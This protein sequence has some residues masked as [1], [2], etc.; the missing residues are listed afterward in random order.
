MPEADTSHGEYIQTVMDRL[1][2][3]DLQ[4]RYSMAIDAGCYDDLDDLFLPDVVADYGAL[5]ELRGVEAVK[6]ACRDALEPLTVAQHVNANH[7]ADLDGDTARAGCY[8]R[9]HQHREGTP[10]GEHFAMGGRYD[11]DVVR[12]PDG[13]RIARRTLRVL[14]AEGNPEVRWGGR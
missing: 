8:F 9:V 12:T 2:I 4:T 11:D 7:W 14:W 6:D 5:G 3:Y 10:G 13:W 1:E